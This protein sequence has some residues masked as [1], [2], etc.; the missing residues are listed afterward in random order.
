MARRLLFQ[1]KEN[2]RVKTIESLRIVQVLM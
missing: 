1:R 2:V